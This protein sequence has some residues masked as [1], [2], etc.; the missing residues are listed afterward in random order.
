VEYRG[1]VGEPRQCRIGMAGCSE[2]VADECG[3]LGEHL[4]GGGAETLSA[5]GGQRSGSRRCKCQMGGRQEAA[6][7]RQ[8]PHASLR[9]EGCST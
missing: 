2:V 1:A 3:V 4:D 6:V 7:D 8:W 9:N 5:G